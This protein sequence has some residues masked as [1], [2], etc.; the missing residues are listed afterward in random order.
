MATVMLLH[1]PEATV[2]LYERVRRGAD[3]EGNRPQGA[4]LHVAGWAEDG[5]HI[6]D[7]WDTP[8]D[9]QAF[10]EARVLPIVQ[11]E[12]VTSQPDVKMFDL[13]GIYAPSFGQTAQVA[14]L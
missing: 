10:F 7:I 3:W 8:G 6:L 11:A 13:H 14:T 2:E 5:L 4:Q 9:F 12:G 1:W